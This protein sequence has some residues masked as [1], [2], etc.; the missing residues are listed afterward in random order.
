[1]AR[2]DRKVMRNFEPNKVELYGGLIL[3]V[4]AITSVSTY[5]IT[6]QIFAMNG[7]QEPKESRDYWLAISS[8][9]EIAAVVF[10]ST[11]NVVAL[12]RCY[13]KFHFTHV[14][15]LEKAHSLRG[16][17]G[18]DLNSDSDNSFRVETAE[19]GDIQVEETDVER[20]MEMKKKPLV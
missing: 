16:G 17:I 8:I 7:S 6:F 3:I 5:M 13:S 2:K 11:W 15:D 10:W 1:M 18:L 9:A 12:Y 14:F 19:L 20:G 4:L